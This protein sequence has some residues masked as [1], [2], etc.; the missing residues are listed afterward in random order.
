MNEPTTRMG[1]L[2]PVCGS[3]GSETVLCLEDLPVLCNALYDTAAEAMATDTADMV[4]DVCRECGMLWNAAFES[5][6][7]AY[8]PGYENSLYG[9]ATF[10]QFAASVCERLADSYELS[11]SHIV[12][13]GTGDGRFLVDLCACTGSTGLGIDPGYVG[14]CRPVPSVRILREE[15]GIV[16]NGAR[17]VVIRHVLEH[18]ASPRDFLIGISARCESAGLLYCEVPN[19]RAMLL[20]QAFWD[21]I[22]EHPLYFSSGPLIELL[23]RCG[24]SAKRLA[25]EYNGQ[26]LC[27]DA[28]KEFSP[29]SGME[30]QTDLDV[31]HAF[32]RGFQET[33][34]LWGERLA[35]WA[36]QGRRIALWGI[37]SK[38]TAFLSAVGGPFIDVLVDVN[39]RKHGRYVPAVG[40][41]VES[42]A[43]L[44]EHS[45]DLVLVSNPLYLDEIKAE[46]EN[47]GVVAELVTLWSMDVGSVRT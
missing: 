20:N 46:I 23:G 34:D 11:G 38:G 8:A 36:D 24:F 43:V 39:E 12:E 40:R 21:L 33:R 27:L 30:L 25:S 22:Y 16:V 42:P 9:S 45:P 17:L 35:T 37:G 6:R 3:G 1:H 28:V 41:P 13:I 18:M 44:S 4:L 32:A 47:L 5:R 26:F 10:Q 2:C 29:V 19:A 14:P 31:V 7:V 15:N